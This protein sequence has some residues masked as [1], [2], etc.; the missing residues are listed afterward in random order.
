MYTY[1]D[2][3]LLTKKM[4][5]IPLLHYIPSYFFRLW[6]YNS[7]KR[8]KTLGRSALCWI[9]KTSTTKVKKTETTDASIITLVT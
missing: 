1:Y 5:Q 9:L 8:H 7:A 2:Q 6:K 4:A 3:E